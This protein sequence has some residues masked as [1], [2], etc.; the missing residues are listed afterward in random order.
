MAWALVPRLSTQWKEAVC[1]CVRWQDRVMWFELGGS[2]LVQCPLSITQAAA[3]R[4]QTRYKMCLVLPSTV[5]LHTKHYTSI[6]HQSQSIVNEAHYQ[7]W[8][9]RDLGVTLCYG[10]DVGIGL[11]IFWASWG[12]NSWYS[13]PYFVT[14]WL[15]V[16]QL[17]GDRCRLSG[18]IGGVPLE[19]Q[20]LVIRVVMALMSRLSQCPQRTEVLTPLH[21]LIP[22]PC[23]FPQNQPVWKSI[24]VQLDGMFLEIT[25]SFIG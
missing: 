21:P 4:F 24:N 5:C 23:S 2:R 13:L 1:V 9:Q 11:V 25:K 12:C 10:Y 7:T 15:R 22:Q 8:L 6:I 18:G 19:C 17:G 14:A 3:E 20:L 16:A